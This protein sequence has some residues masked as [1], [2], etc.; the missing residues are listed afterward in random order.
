MHEEKKT[1]TTETTSDAAKQEIEQAPVLE[2]KPQAEEKPLSDQKRSALL[3]YMAVLFAVAFLLV[4]VSLLIQTHSSKAAI[5]EMS[6]NNSDA[7]SN[8]MANAEILQDQN[9]QLQEDNKA[10]RAQIDELEAQANASTEDDDQ[11]QVLEA[12]LD[13]LKSQLYSAQRDTAH[14]QEAYDA[15][16]TAFQC[17]TH[18]GNLTFSKAMDTVE[19]Y[20]EYLS[21][22]ALAV[23]EQLLG[24]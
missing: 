12:E 16:I 17:E 21:S 23:Y 2:S 15:L 20:K 11:V 10:L 5:S 7:L 22:D 1:D 6:K 9:R 24:E 19:Q 18:E 4:L 3:R 8:A 14:A 13:E